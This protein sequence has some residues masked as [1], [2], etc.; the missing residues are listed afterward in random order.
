MEVPV[1]RHSFPLLPPLNCGDIPLEISCDLFP[2]IE[3]VFRGFLE[4]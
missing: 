4:S 2:G 3:L 1:D